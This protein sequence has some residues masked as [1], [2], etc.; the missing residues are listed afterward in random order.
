MADTVTDPLEKA[1]LSGAIFAGPD[2]EGEE[3]RRTPDH[4]DFEDDDGVG[5]SA[6][7]AEQS[8]AAPGSSNGPVK[9]TKGQSHNTG[10]K[11][12]LADYRNRNN[13]KGSTAGHKK[14][15]GTRTIRKGVKGLTIETEEG[16]ESTDSLDD[17]LAEADG[18]SD[19]GEQDARD[20][21]RR[22][23]IE[24]MKMMGSQERRTNATQERYGHLREIGQDQFIKAIEDKSAHC[25]MVHVYDIVSLDVLHSSTR[26]AR[27]ID[28]FK[29]SVYSIML[30]PEHTPHKSC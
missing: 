4:S 2:P 27:L 30:C 9:T 29:L 14:K 7:F 3:P 8:N 25:V 17:L 23:R 18:L 13:G 26:T 1:V 22:K 15:N 24:E 21:Y 28:A 20:A 16:N 10:V 5:P 6:G 19:G 11:G 12:V